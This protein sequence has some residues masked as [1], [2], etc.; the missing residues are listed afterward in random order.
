[1]DDSFAHWAGANFDLLRDLFALGRFQDFPEFR[2]KTE[3]SDLAVGY[4]AL[5]WSFSGEGRTG[6]LWHRHCFNR[7][8]IRLLRDAEG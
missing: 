2:T 1:M 5:N 4:I 7:L 8:R 6:Q 3:F